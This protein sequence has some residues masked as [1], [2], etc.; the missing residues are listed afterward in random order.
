MAKTAID[1][2]SKYL[3]LQ[4]YAR[5]RGIRIIP[6]QGWFWWML[7]YI[8]KGITFGGND[9]FIT[10]YVT[11]L[12]K[13]IAVP[14]EGEYLW[15]DRHARSRYLCLR[16][17][18]VH[19]DQFQ[20]F[21]LGYYTLG[22]IPAFFWYVLFPLPVFFAYGRWRMERVAYLEA[23]QA[24]YELEGKVHLKVLD[25]AVDQ[26][27]GPSYAWTWKPSKQVREWFLEHM[28][29]EAWKQ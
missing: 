9:R 24:R 25:H 10:R 26:L 28:P 2:E 19:C 15:E 5:G 8:I 6:K 11:T 16:H 13:W 27:S 4:D 7:H 21:G 23:M 22:I 17:E 12:G 3:E 18:L 14:V 29:P 20:R 1:W